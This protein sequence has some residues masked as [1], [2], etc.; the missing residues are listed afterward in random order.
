[1][2]LN[3][4]IRPSGEQN[5]PADRLRVTD[6]GI[7]NLC[8]A[9]HK[10]E[11][12]KIN[13]PP[14]PT[15]EEIGGDAVLNALAP[16]AYLTRITVQGRTAALNAFIKRIEDGNTHLAITD[17]ALGAANLP[18]GGPQALRNDQE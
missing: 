18:A 5:M 17:Q 12:E 7:T 8:A 6:E 13:P 14:Q 11:P 15:A 9:L 1:V 2:L 4:D 3:G 16:V 10:A